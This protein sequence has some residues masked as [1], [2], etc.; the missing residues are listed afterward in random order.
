M[1]NDTQFCTNDNGYAQLT[2]VHSDHDSSEYQLSHHSEE[3]D[4]PTPSSEINEQDDDSSSSYRHAGLP[5]SSTNNIEDYYQYASR[6]ASHNQLI[7]Q[8]KNDFGIGSLLSNNYQVSSSNLQSQLVSPSSSISPQP[9]KSQQNQ[10]NDVKSYL[11]APPDTA[12]L[13][14]ASANQSLA[15]SKRRTRIKFN[16]TQ[17]DILEATFEKTHYPDVSVVDKLSDVLNLGSERISIWFQNRRARYKKAKNSGKRVPSPP[18]IPP[19]RSDGDEEDS[20]SIQLP[21]LEK[22]YQ[23]YLQNTQSSFKD[24]EQDDQVTRDVDYDQDSLSPSD[25]TNSNHERGLQAHQINNQNLQLDRTLDN[26][27]GSDDDEDDQQEQLQQIQLPIQRSTSTISLNNQNNHSDYQAN[28][29][30]YQSC[31]QQH[32]LMLQNYYNQ[33]ASLPGYQ[34]YGKVPTYNYL[35]HPSGLFQ[36][37]SDYA[38]QPQ[39]YYPSQSSTYG[40]ANFY[41]NE[42]EED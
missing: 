13:A 36:P 39:H 38:N 37:Y 30:Y 40:Y 20:S 4:Y 25:K 34:Y 19:A 18:R 17:L 10:E 6:Y 1:S 28:Q 11:L 32:P 3:R 24:D 31:D 26:K 27:S 21:F 8:A 14:A 9:Y 7:Q 2:P 5:I 35:T 33:L 15:K 41:K 22:A 42:N 29:L 23:N 16:K 12:S